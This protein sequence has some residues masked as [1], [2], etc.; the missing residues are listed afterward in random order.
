MW[1]GWLGA[2]GCP[3]LSRRRWRLAFATNDSQAC[4]TRLRQRLLFIALG[5]TIGPPFSVPGWTPE[6]SPTIQVGATRSRCQSAGKRRTFR[7]TAMTSWRLATSKVRGPVRSC[8]LS[9]SFGSTK[10]SRSTARRFSPRL[11]P[12]SLDCVEPF[13]Q[14]HG[15]RGSTQLSFM[16]EINEDVARFHL[17]WQLCV[18]EAQLA[19]RSTCGPKFGALGPTVQL[20]R[21]IS[22]AQCVVAPLQPR[23]DHIAGDIGHARP[24]LGVDVGDR[25]AG[26]AG[27]MDE[28]RCAEAR[29]AH[30]DDMVELAS[31]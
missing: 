24:A 7:S 13:D 2:C 11:A 10:V 18:D 17:R 26:V 14:R 9:S 31:I 4:R 30:L 1:R 12:L 6:H 29:M 19:W 8:A 23:I 28:A 22:S 5:R 21:L 16:N 25:S 27:K 3:M 15:C 20:L